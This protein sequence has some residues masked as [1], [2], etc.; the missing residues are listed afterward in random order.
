MRSLSR[1]RSITCGS[2]ALK[3]AP[4][5]YPLPACG[6]RGALTS[7][8]PS[9][10]SLR[11]EGTGEGQRLCSRRYPPIICRRDKAQIRCLDRIETS[12]QCRQY[13]IYDGVP[14]D[15]CVDVPEPHHRP[16]LRHHEPITPPVILA[17]EML[18]SIE[19]DNEPAL[20]TGEIG[21]IRPDRQ[22]TGEFRTV[23]LA[24]FQ[25]GPKRLFGIVVCLAKRSRPAGA[26]LVRSAHQIAPHPYPLPARGERGAP[27]LA[28]LPPRSLRG[29]C[30]REA[31]DVVTPTS[32]L[33][34]SPR[35]PSP[36]AR[37]VWRRGSA[38]T[39]PRRRTC[40]SSGIRSRRSG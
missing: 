15:Q 2:R 11:G 16:A 36:P 27:A 39:P 26:R 33:P 18:A 37:A 25:L 24:S 6:E 8:I 31:S 20:S 10:R 4:H 23:Q 38:S 12:F 14:L 5:P 17:F 1:R 7:A 9:P 30:E 21:E 3:I 19:F 28:T 34:S 29:I 35:S 13:R 22:L 40:R 32:P